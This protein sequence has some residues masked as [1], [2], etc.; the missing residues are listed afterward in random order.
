MCGSYDYGSAEDGSMG[1]VVSEDSRKRQVRYRKSSKPGIIFLSLLFLA[2]YF[3][4]AM[5][6]FL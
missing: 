6:V 4:K 5:N 2:V 3:R 1:P